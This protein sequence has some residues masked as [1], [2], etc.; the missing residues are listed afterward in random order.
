[1]LFFG[2]LY[3]QIIPDGNQFTDVLIY[4]VKQ[5]GFVIFILQICTREKDSC[6]RHSVAG[7][8]P[9]NQGNTE[10][11]QNKLYNAMY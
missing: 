10:L 6:Y 11:K 3:T 1:M 9:N 2:L 8:S 5:V 4:R 7:F